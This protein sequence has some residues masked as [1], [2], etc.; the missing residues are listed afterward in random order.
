[1]S[2][3]FIRKSVLENVRTLSAFDYLN[4]Y[5]PSLLVKNGK[6]DYY[7]REHESL[8]FSN[9]KW[10]W[11]SQGVGGTTALDYLIAVEGYD[12]KEACNYLASLM[13]IS[14]PVVTYYHKKETTPFE[15]PEKDKNNNLVIRYLC[16]TRKIDR[17]IVDYFI[18]TGM[19]YQSAN[20]RNAVFVGY[21]GDMPAY[22]FKRNIFKDFKLEHIGSNKAF[23]FNYQNKESNVLHVF[24]AAIDLLSYATYLKCEGKDYR[25]QNL[26]SLSGVY[27]PKKELSESKVPIA[28]S[29]YLKENPQ[30]KTVVLHL[31]NDKTGRLCTAALTELLKKDYEIVDSPPP[32]GK[33]VNDFLMSY[34]GLSRQ[35]PVRERSD[36]R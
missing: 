31:D 32:V 17:E 6:K 22:A 20:F 28:L 33:D 1:M 7:H 24:E 36:V 4:N 3:K 14:D 21:D 11:W 10:Y 27:Q 26:L 5:H 9:G 8:H 13:N 34:L 25:T 23:S 30:V 12:F 2:K 29:T 18:S 35:K 19:L 16:E 15:L